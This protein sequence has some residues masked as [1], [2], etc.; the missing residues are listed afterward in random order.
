MTSAVVVDHV[1]RRYR[2]VTALDDV[3]VAFEDGAITG[4]LGRNGAGKST[5]MRV[6][7]GQE[8]VSAGTVRVHGADAFDRLQDTFTNDLRRI[9]P[10]Q[11]AGSGLQVGIPE[12]RQGQRLGWCCRLGR[13]RPAAGLP[14]ALRAGGEL[15]LQH[16]GRVVTE[17]RLGQRDGLRSRRRKYEVVP[18]QAVEVRRKP[19]A[20][21][22]GGRSAAGIRGRDG[23]GLRAARHP[24]GVPH[25]RKV[26]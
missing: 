3:T 7:T 19:V 21:P 17:R 18:A 6:I 9:G 24:T 11:A 23:T 14:A 4:L 13:R 5:L 26:P 2:G 25:R 10:G 15:A 22:A 20:A 16:A 1:S 12:R 8:F